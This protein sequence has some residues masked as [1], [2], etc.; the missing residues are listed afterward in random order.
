MVHVPVL[1]MPC[2]GRLLVDP[3]TARVCVHPGAIENPGMRAVAIF[4]YIV[5]P[6]PVILLESFGWDNVGACVMLVIVAIATLLLLTFSS[7][8]KEKEAAGKTKGK[9][10]KR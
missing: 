2:R 7:G 8:K 5:S 3:Y 9:E 10:E 6:I 4:L 1:H